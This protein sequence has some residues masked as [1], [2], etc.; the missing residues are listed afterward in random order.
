MVA[1]H[2]KEISLFEVRVLKRLICEAELWCDFIIQDFKTDVSDLLCCADDRSLLAEVSDDEAE[3]NS[4]H[5]WLVVIDL[6]WQGRTID[7]E[8]T[9]GFSHGI[10]C[11]CIGSP[12]VLTVLTC[13][14]IYMHNLYTL[15]RFP[16]RDG[17][18]KL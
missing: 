17:R 4:F 7:I 3:M 18:D 13:N 11:L 10:S 12:Y 15:L 1:I 5:F 2:A 6:C 14:Q 16:F 8:S 9:T